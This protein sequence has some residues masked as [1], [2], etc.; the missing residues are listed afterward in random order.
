MCKPS[1]KWLKGVSKKNMILNWALKS[2]EIMRR[3]LP[4]QPLQVIDKQTNHDITMQVNE[5]ALCVCAHSARERYWWIIILMMSIIHSCSR[6]VC[7]PTAHE[8]IMTCR[9]RRCNMEQLASQNASDNNHAPSQNRIHTLQLIVGL[10][11]ARLR[12]LN[13]GFI[14]VADFA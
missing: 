11:D 7:S 14:T 1:G 6:A 10:D 13:K 2:C 9:G 8:L 3:G 5:S 12:N 4:N